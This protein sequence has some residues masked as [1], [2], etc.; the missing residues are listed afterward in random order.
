M[1]VAFLVLL[2]PV[3]LAQLAGNSITS[4]VLPCGF[5][6]SGRTFV[7]TLVDGVFSRAECSDRSGNVMNRC[8]PCCAMKA[9][10]KHPD[11]LPSMETASAASS[12][13]DAKTFRQ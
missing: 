6:C 7:T 13:I 5:S 9:L 1:Q 2:L 4:G 10:P 11:C 12:T 3:A 8:G